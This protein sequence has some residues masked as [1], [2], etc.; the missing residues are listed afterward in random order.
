M[1]NNIL[2]NYYF[3]NS[4]KIRWQALEDNINS[5]LS[6]KQ[7]EVFI[8]NNVKLEN[9]NIP[10]IRKINVTTLGN[11]QYSFYVGFDI[12]DGKYTFKFAKNINDDHIT[13]LDTLPELIKVITDNI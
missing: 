10:M 7:N 2:A 5:L 12:T 8:R 1:L 9:I 3:T 4:Y 11:K 13:K 6:I